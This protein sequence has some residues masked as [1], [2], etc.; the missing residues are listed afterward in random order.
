MNIIKRI[1]IATISMVAVL[2]A[3][4][5]TLSVYARG[6]DSTES[7]NAT[8][9]SSTTTHREN[10]TTT[11]DQTTNT[12]E[13]ENSTEQKSASDKKKLSTE[14]KLKA[15]QKRETVINN[16]LSRMSDRGQKQLDLFTSI[17]T[18]TKAFYVA[19]GKT[20]SNYDALVAVVNAKQAAAQAAVNAIKATS[21]TF[22]CDGSDPK[23]VASS[24]KEQLKS[25]IAAL[26][27]YKTAVKNLIKGVKSVQSTE[28][29]TDNT[30]TESN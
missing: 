17:A 9:T 3:V 10:E 16:S 1:S 20:L 26:K 24:F 4:G 28:A 19:K 25:E 21:V 5:P 27:E 15:C 14:A 30:K 12:H 23:G 8:N 18:K 6:S 7:T 11:E 13:T 29:T 2:L 22:K